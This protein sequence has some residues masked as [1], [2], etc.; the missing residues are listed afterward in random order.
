VSYLKFFRKTLLKISFVA[1]I[2]LISISNAQAQNEAI[3][4]AIKVNTDNIL[5]SINAF[6][7]FLSNLVTSSIISFISQTWLLPDDDANGLSTHLRANFVAMDTL[8]LNSALAQT[9]KQLQLTADLFSEDPHKSA[10]NLA[11]FTAGDGVADILKALP[12]INDLVYTTLLGAPPVA[13]GAPAGDAAFNYIK[14]A[15]GIGIHHYL[16]NESW[17]RKPALEKYKEYY[18]TVTAI[19]S[20]N[21]YVLSNL[22]TEGNQFNALQ[23]KLLKQATDDSENSWFTKV[24]SE[25]LS[26]VFRQI[27]MYQSQIFVLMT[28]L[29]QLQ[30]QT[31]T[32]QA[33]TNTLLIATNKQAEGL[34]VSQAQGVLPTP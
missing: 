11:N 14:N 20:F 6:P 18:N 2:S 1:C 32:A 4:N 30:K 23:T 25:H 31:L 22:Y 28:Q 9:N 13:R 12:N 15:S 7:S 17:V 33:M 10:Q 27:L 19:E 8:F 16:P 5:S 21:G 29:L 3:L 34:L 26:V 24:S